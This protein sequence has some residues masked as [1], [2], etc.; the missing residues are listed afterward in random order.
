MML[1]GEKE[2][3]SVISLFPQEGK[4]KNEET[5]INESVLGHSFLN[6]AFKSE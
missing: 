5:Y 4:R 2:M 1:E 3:P 6:K